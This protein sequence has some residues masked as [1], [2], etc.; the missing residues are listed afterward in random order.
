MVF[1]V[2]IKQYLYFY[3]K[4]DTANHLDMDKFI[5]SELLTQ[6]LSLNSN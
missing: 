3:K 1:R 6:P 5:I 4:A 2:V